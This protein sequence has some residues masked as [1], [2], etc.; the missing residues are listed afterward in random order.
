MQRNSLRLVNSISFRYFSLLS[1]D[2]TKMQKET[3]K[4]DPQNVKGDRKI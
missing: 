4:F 2:Y 3:E 1:I